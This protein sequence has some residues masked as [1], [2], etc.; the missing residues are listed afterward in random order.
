MEVRVDDGKIFIVL[1]IYI[2]VCLIRL[3]SYMGIIDE[4]FWLVF[5]MLCFISFMFLV[6]CDK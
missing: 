6:F 3:V 1:Y 5:V 2:Y 4:L